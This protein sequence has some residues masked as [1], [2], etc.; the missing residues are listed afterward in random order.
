[1]E[2]VDKDQVMENLLDHDNQFGIYQKNYGT[3]MKGFKQENNL[4]KLST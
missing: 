1:M 4:I 2:A 3:P